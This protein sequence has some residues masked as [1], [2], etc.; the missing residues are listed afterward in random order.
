M[1]VPTRLALTTVN[2][3]T[4]DPAALARFYARLLGWDI[5]VEEAD[6]VILRGPDGGVGLSFQRE[7]AY[8]RPTWPA[9]PGRQQMMMHLE[10]GVEDLVAALDHALACGATLA[11]FQPQDDVRVCLDPDGHPFCLWLTG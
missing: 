2:L 9:E 1:T 11:E 5:E 8:A 7:R 6:D 4:P 10:I 3:D